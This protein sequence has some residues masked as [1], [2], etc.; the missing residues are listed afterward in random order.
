MKTSKEIFNE[1]FDKYTAL[2]T[3]SEDISAAYE[4]LLRCAE[5][6]ALIMVCGNGGSAADCE[7]ITAELMKG[8]N[9]SRPLTRYQKEGFIDIDG[10]EA[11]AEKLQRGIRTISLASQTGLISAFAN[12]IDASLVYAQQVF[13]YASSE[14]DSLIALS[15]SGNSENI[16]NAVKTAAAAGIKTVAITGQTGGKLKDISDVTIKLPALNTFEVQ[17]LTLPVYHAICAALEA[18]MFGE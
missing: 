2:K 17:E 5:E 14:F 7:H 8:F 12:D 1:L 15:T 6:N 11:I 3:C 13:T 18:E 9:L 16:L 10:G 4:V